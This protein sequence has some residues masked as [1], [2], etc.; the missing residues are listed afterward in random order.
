M[1]SKKD[2]NLS[3]KIPWISN[4]WNKEIVGQIIVMTSVAVIAPT[5]DHRTLKYTI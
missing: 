4:D 2:S 1:T 3:M 5:T